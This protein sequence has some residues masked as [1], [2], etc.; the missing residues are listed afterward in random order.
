VFKFLI[1]NQKINKNMRTKILTLALF[2]I[3]AMV[4]HAKEPDNLRYEIECAGKE[5]VQG[6]YLVKVWVYTK[7][8]KITSEVLK[9]Y[10][11]HGVI[12]KGY[13]GKSGCVAQRPMAQ[14]PA[15]EQEKA[16]FFKSFFNKD[17]T[18]AKYAN[19][20]SG[21]LERVKVG[22]DYKYGMTV[23]V[24]KYLLRKDLEAAGIIRGLTEGF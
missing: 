23:T 19:E 11:V 21:S 17:K 20:V 8:K 22:K 12:F 5:A 7:E 6:S 2:C 15:L 13:A 10:A 9:R 1:N 18:F 3:L 24:S 14:S 4:V 16:D